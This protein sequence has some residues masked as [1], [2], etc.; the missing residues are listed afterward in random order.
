MGGLFIR[1]VED[2]GVWQILFYR[3][4]AFSILVA[5]FLLTAR[6]LGKSG[7][8][9]MPT[10]TVIVAAMSL[11]LAFILYVFSVQAT[12]VGNV[13]LILSAA[14]FVIALLSV[15]VLKARVPVSTW[16]FIAVG[17]SGVL[18]IVVDDM[19]VRFD[20]GIVYATLTMLTY[21]LFIVLLKADGRVDMMMATFLAGVFAA[22]ISFALADGL[23]M[24][25]N[26]LRF[27]VSLGIVQIGVQYIFITI[28]SRMIRAE[29]IALVLL[30]EVILAP[31]WVFLAFGET[32]SAA[33]L[34]AAPLILLAVAGQA[35]T[36]LW[37]ERRAR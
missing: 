26:D 10:P 37:R 19:M 4:V 20:E 35:V 7:G 30:L 23:V 18:V 14:P 24:T 32:L 22:V 36:A 15:V 9:A 5:L 31:L 3:S 1:H 27:A 21:S 34:L 17:V 8:R 33:T 2:A 25:G 13:V 29:E 28:A 11:A 16:A 12:T 6:W